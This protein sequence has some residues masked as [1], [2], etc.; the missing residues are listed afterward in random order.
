MKRAL[1]ILAVAAFAAGC[2]S[3]DADE[4]GQTEPPEDEIAVYRSDEVAFTFEYPSDLTAET[5]RQGRLLGQ[6]SLEPGAPLDAIKIRKTADRPLPPA[7]YLGEFQ[8]DF[9]EAVGEVERRTERI[10]DRTVGV[11]SFE[12]TLQEQGEDVPFASTSYFFAGAGATWQVECISRR[13]HREQID[14][15]CLMALESVDFDGGE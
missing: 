9:A 12:D 2:G 13:E 6:V 11:L 10:G 3:D 14:E 4:A 5:E 1:L 8:R 15:A 7:R